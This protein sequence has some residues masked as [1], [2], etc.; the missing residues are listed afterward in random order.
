MKR[1]EEI[2]TVLNIIIV[3]LLVAIIVKWI[4]LK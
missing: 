2:K 3:I 4:L 1:F